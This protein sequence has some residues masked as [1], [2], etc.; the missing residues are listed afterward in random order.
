MA[1]GG[2]SAREAKRTLPEGASLAREIAIA[3]VGLRRLAC[4]EGGCRPASRP[5]LERERMFPRPFP[6]NWQRTSAR[7]EWILDP[8]LAKLLE[9]NRQ[10]DEQRDERASLLVESTR[11]VEDLV[12]NR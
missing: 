1:R 3:V 4:T 11:I 8:R 9:I 5:R 10:A 6:A 12:Q 2:R 7:S